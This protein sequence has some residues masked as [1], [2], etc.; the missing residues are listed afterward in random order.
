ME[1][2]RKEGGVQ[3]L[4]LMELCCKSVC[5]FI[6]NEM[7]KVDASEAKKVSECILCCF[8]M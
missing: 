2:L 8:M 1:L 6:G 4:L 5:F 7:V 3:E